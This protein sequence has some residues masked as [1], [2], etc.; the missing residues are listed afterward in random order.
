MT[1]RRHPFTL[2]EVLIATI[3][4]A[5]LSFALFGYSSYATSAWQQL[6][7]RRNQL[8]EVLTV[9]R[10]L[11]GILP[12]VIPFNWPDPDAETITEIP[13]L[14][15]NPDS[16]RCAYLHRLNDLEEG[17]IRF[18]EIF[19]ADN[20][21]LIRYSDR[22][23]INWEDA[24]DRVWTSTIAENV[25]SI[26]FQYAD[27]QADITADNWQDR[28]IWTDT[29]ENTDDNERFDVPLAVSIQ[30]NWLDGRSHTWFRRTMGNGYRER[31]GKWDAQDNDD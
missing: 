19:V 17:A 11:Q 12:H 7:V 4:F 2:L 24:G 29:W 14:V 8:A 30:I 21:L 9:D 31:F 6:Q 16:L 27:W 23:F 5:G 1:C 20:N 25:E 3:L 18:C 10:A 13:F 22:P 28:A 15:A 26:Q